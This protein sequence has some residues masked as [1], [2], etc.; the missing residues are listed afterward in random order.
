[1]LFVLHSE[2]LER[3]HLEAHRDDMNVCI[4]C[5]ESTTTARQL[6]SHMQEHDDLRRARRHYPCMLCPCEFLRD[7]ER[8]THYEKFHQIEAM[9]VFQTPKMATILASWS[10][11]NAPKPFAQPDPTTST[12][13]VM[14]GP[15]CNELTAP[16]EPLEPT[17]E[18][19]RKTD[20]PFPCLLC[21]CV[22]NFFQDREVHIANVHTNRTS[23]L[24]RSSLSVPHLPVHP[25][26]PEESDPTVPGSEPM[27]IDNHR[28]LEPSG[29]PGIPTTA[30]QTR[31]TSL[32]DWTVS[33]KLGLK[34]SG[35]YNC[36]SLEPPQKRR[37]MDS[38]SMPMMQD[39]S[40]ITNV[41]EL[42]MSLTD[43]GSDSY[44]MLMNFED[45]SSNCDT[46]E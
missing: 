18:Y 24:I 6:Q 10:D 21:P 14:I 22:F 3:H 16:L 20:R 36:I 46:T 38:F 9:P 4:L 34:F 41:G 37:T 15:R 39:E 42:F 12:V 17:Q 31:S 13:E 33:R 7:I 45:N 40:T 44:Y 19:S 25:A 8:K 35:D 32:Y 27:I 1:M 23:D 2:H 5:G 11:P 28:Q 29:P 30:T 26:Q 43:M